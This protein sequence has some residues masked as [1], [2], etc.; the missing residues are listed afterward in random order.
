MAAKS[1]QATSL[2]P[3][4]VRRSENFSTGQGNSLDNS[5][6]VKKVRQSQNLGQSTYK[7]NTTAFSVI[8]SDI[9]TGK[10]KFTPTVPN[11]SN[12]YVL[13]R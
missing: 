3:I 6:R 13:H 1:F 11:S 7:R 2:S 9:A 5:H 8:E 10:S 12:M 4:A